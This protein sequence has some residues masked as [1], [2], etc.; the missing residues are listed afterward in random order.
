MGRGI[1]APPLPFFVAQT[2]PEPLRKRGWQPH[3]NPMKRSAPQSALF[4][5]TLLLVFMAVPA[6]AQVQP[7]PFLDADPANHDALERG[8]SV[9]WWLFG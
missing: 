2:C 9:Q 8:F 5:L 3:T 7:F 6:L 4:V 1:L